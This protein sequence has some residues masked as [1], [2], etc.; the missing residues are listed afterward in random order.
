MFAA[1]TLLTAPGAMRAQTTV[2]IGNESSTNSAYIMP[3][4]MYYNYSLT[5]QIYRANEINMPDGGT[6]TSISFEYLYS[7]AFSLSGIKVFMKNT[8]KESFT[9]NNDWVEV[10][11][12]DK[13]FEGTFSASGAGWVTLTLNTPF[14][15]D[16]TSN[17]LVC[18]YDPT[19]G[20]PGSSYKFRTTSTTSDYP[21]QY[22]ALTCNS[23]SYVPDPDDLYSYSGAK[24]L[25]TIR[26]NIRLTIN[27]DITEVYVNDFTLPA[28]GE[29][30]DYSWSIPSGVNYYI[31]N[32]SSQWKDATTSGNIFSGNVFNQ[33]GHNYVLTLKFNSIYG[34]HISSNATVYLNG[35]TNL[36][37]STTLD[38][39]GHFIAQTIPFLMVPGHVVTIGEGT[40]SS[41][42][43]PYASM[44]NYSVTEQ[45]YTANEIG[46]PNGGTISSIRFQRQSDF[47][48]T[49]HITVYMKNVSR[50]SFADLSDPETLLPTDIVYEGDYTFT[51]GWSNIDLDLPFQYVLKKIL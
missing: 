7:E 3:V 2:T 43:T 9:N 30:P 5:Q 44:W 39:G 29:H 1:L 27:P 17:L 35:V 12:S 32:S 20:Y 21:G 10:S 11:A 42:E 4:N 24:G 48:E 6:I 34:W 37:A 45:I 40:S 14:H 31:D 23:D 26:N 50:S 49:N 13:V 15:Y 36:I 8:T 33:E 41:A 51:Q 46:V 16:G 47:L 19:N 18:F 22:L 25:Q 38:A 28:W